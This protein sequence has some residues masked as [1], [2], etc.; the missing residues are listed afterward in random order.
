MSLILVVDDEP[1]IQ[2]ALQMILV[3]EGYDV[4]TAF[5]GEEGLRLAIEKQPHLIISDIMMPRMNGTE[6]C[7]RLRQ[8]PKTR[9]I[10]II[11]SSSIEPLA[12]SRDWDL[13][14]RKTTN[15]DE[16]LSAIQ[17]LSKSRA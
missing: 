8:D 10:P 11:V 1:D 13:F 5:D 15:L 6:M 7:Q 16:L 4:I 14:L 17:R 3:L 12:E 2:N 9:D